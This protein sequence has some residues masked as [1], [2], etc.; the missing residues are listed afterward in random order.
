MS[1]SVPSNLFNTI[2]N[3]YLEDNSF[4]VGADL[5]QADNDVFAVISSAPSADKLPHLSRWY[6][7]IKSQSGSA[8]AA[9]DD[10]DIDLFGSDDEEVDE[11]AEKLKQQRLEEYRAKKAAKGPGPVA[12]SMITLDVK[13]WDD[14]TDLAEMERLVRSIAMEGLEWKS[15]Q[16][17]AIGYG[18][19]KLRISCVVIDEHVSTDLLE[20]KIAE[21]EDFVQSIDVEAFQKL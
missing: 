9:D 20:E 6:N 10:E 7:H 14:E 19:K 1:V 5:S 13:P 15:A 12:K 2:L 4:I 8:V 16:L 11:E 17:V 3:G 18:I 21:F